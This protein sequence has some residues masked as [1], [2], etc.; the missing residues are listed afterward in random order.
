LKYQQNFRDLLVSQKLD[1]REIEHVRKF[2]PFH[3]HNHVQ[4]K[5]NRAIGTLIY[6]ENGRGSYGAGKVVV[7]SA[8]YL[9]EPNELS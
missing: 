7:K 5:Q 6:Y 4:K 8:V 2:Y 1:I 9:P 3:G